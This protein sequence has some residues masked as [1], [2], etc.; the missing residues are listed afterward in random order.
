[1]AVALLLLTVEFVT[2]DG[3]THGGAERS[4]AARRITRHQR[5]R[6][7][8]AAAGR[9]GQP[10]D[11]C[12]ARAVSAVPGDR[13][14]D[15]GQGWKA[16]RLHRWQDRKPT[17]VAVLSLIVELITVSVGELGPGEDGAGGESG[18]GCRDQTRLPQKTTAKITPHGSSDDARC[19]PR[20]GVT[21]A[22]RD[23]RPGKRQ[24]VG[25]PVLP[26]PTDVLP[27]HLLIETTSGT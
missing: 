3:V 9:G 20:T 24:P 11:R 6:Q 8:H 2:F 12:T 18:E 10:A 1:M 15:H 13:R 23:V 27:C 4:G 22:E 5:R 7:R 21:D 16:P 14:A 17:T 19:P 26:G 25:Y